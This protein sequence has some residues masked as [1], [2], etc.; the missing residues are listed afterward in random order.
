MQ[1]EVPQSRHPEVALRLQN[2]KSAGFTGF[3]AVARAS[4]LPHCACNC[5][6]A[7]GPEA[8]LMEGLGLAAYGSGSDDD[9]INSLGGDQTSL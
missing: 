6:V 3:V 4:D 5:A 7:A 1:L 8:W 9:E 2:C